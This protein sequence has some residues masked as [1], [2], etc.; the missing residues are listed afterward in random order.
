MDMDRP[1]VEAMF[2][3]LWPADRLVATAD[4]LHA[5]GL[6]T[7]FIS[8]GV[9][10]GL[11]VR[12]R[13]GVY[14]PRY[15]WTGKP[16]WQQAKIRLAAHIAV[17]HGALV[18]THFSAARLHGLHTWDCPADIHANA[19]YQSSL[20]SSSADVKLHNFEIPPGDIVHKFFAGIGT[21][22][23][24]DLARTVLDCA[25]TASF[26]QAV[27]IGDSALHHGLTMEQLN[28]ALMAMGGR[29]GVKMARKVVRALNALSESAGES[30]TRLIMADLPIPP[31][32][33]QITL[34]VDGDDYRP[35]FAWREAKLIVEFDGNGKY[36]DYTSTPDALIKERE[37]ESALMEQGWTFVRF[38]W[39]HLENPEQVCARIFAAYQRAV[40]A[41]AA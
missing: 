39:K 2:R 38:K 35:D 41:Q 14:V 21:T 8:D 25:M 26:A 34:T 20:R 29:K 33:L 40:G 4:Q 7:R 27:V 31:P 24:T 28:A 9:R 11:L 30:R 22:Q 3:R 10:M 23:F 36:F 19:G 16:P 6:G 32:E 15:R 13:R 37:R 18:Y 1:I 17:S 12:L 5:A